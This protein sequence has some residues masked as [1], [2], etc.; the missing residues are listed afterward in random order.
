[1][2]A[3]LSR[4]SS[5]S[6]QAIWL[7]VW[8]VGVAA[9]RPLWGQGVAEG[10]SDAPAELHSPRQANGCP[11]CLGALV[12]LLQ[13]FSA[14]SLACV[15]VLGVVAA[16]CEQ[17]TA[18]LALCQMLVLGAVLALAWHAADQK[19]MGLNDEI[20]RVERHRAGCVASVEF[21]PRWVRIESQHHVNPSFACRA[22][23]G[24]SISVSMSSPRG[25]GSWPANSAVPFA[26]WAPAQRFEAFNPKL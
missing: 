7:G 11:Q 16:L 24:R 15:L 2:P 9:T 22:R 6:A 4:G 17:S 20:L 23:A 19:F 5:V 1:M 8:N 3:A 14:Y 26:Y 18:P 21:D 13:W 25:A 10:V 12:L